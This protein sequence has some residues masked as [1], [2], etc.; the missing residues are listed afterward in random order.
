MNRKESKKKWRQTNAERLRI[1]QCNY[2]ATHREEGRIYMQKYRARK[3]KMMVGE[4]DIIQ[5]AM[6]VSQTFNPLDDFVYNHSERQSN[7][8]NAVDAIDFGFSQG[9]PVSSTVPTM[10]QTSVQKLVSHRIGPLPTSSAS[11][12]PEKFDWFED[13]IDNSYNQSVLTSEIKNCPGMESNIADMKAELALLEDN[14]FF[15]H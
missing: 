13:I 8:S 7:Q 14:S 1:Y 3:K 10:H 6:Q 2:R 11:L 12:T 15:L 5:Q 9:M 4:G